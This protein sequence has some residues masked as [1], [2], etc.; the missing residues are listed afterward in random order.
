M[1]SGEPFK[2]AVSTLNLCGRPN[3]TLQLPVFAGHGDPESITPQ[4]EIVIVKIVVRP[5]LPS[6]SIVHGPPA[7]EPVSVARQS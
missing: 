2:I 4:P 7:A 6:H 3:S 1:V 5:R